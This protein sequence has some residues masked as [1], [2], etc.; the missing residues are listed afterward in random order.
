MGFAYTAYDLTGLTDDDTAGEDD[1]PIGTLPI[2]FEVA[3]AQIVAEDGQTIATDNLGRVVQG[4][5][6]AVMSID[7]PARY[8]AFGGSGITYDVGLEQ[9]MAAVE[10]A[11][12]TT[13]VDFAAEDD[14]VFTGEPNVL[15]GDYVYVLSAMSEAW[16]RRPVSGH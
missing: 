16:R 3:T 8:M 1:I 13:P 5:C 12:F 9:E 2:P 4:Q 7:Y 15:A 10:G 11:G 6:D 14:M